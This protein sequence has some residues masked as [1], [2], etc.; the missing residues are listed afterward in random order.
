[1]QI[2]RD[3]SLLPQNLKGSIYAIGNFDGLHLGHRSVIEKARKISIDNN[4]SLGVLTFDPHPRKV[5][6]LYGILNY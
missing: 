4:V 3:F 5:I 2:F 6:S 1:M